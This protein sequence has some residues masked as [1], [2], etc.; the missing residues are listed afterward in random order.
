MSRA[1]WLGLTLL[2]MTFAAAAQ[3]PDCPIRDAPMATRP[4]GKPPDLLPPAFIPP[5]TFPARFED[6]RSPSPGPVAILPQEADL[7]DAEE[8]HLTALAKSAELA[9]P[10]PPPADVL[11][12][13]V[14]PGKTLL[15]AW[16]FEGYMPNL[17]WTRPRCD[18][19]G[20][21]STSTRH[22]VKRIFTRDGSTLS[23]EEWNMKPDG[24]SIVATL[25]PTLRIGRFAGHTTGLRSPSG[26]VM[27]T[28]AWQGEGR[29]F[30]L[31][32][33]GPL[34]PDRQR[35]LL[36]EVANSMAL[37]APWAK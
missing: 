20:N 4:P 23:L 28:L 29:S 24:A 21:C 34:S 17:S 1:R 6:V 11:A 3:R 37:V 13:I 14:D 2:V 5:P 7:A 10:D 15:S 33:V 30:T 12:E 19:Q 31:A 16:R 18:A 32:I 8:G 9:R 26:C 27:A 35:Q 22:F 25:P 36:L